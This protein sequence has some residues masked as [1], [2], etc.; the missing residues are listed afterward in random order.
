MTTCNRS[1]LTEA[2]AIEA[3]KSRPHFWRKYQC[4]RCGSWHLASSISY[5]LRRRKA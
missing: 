1:P 3:L 4:N 5:G 2:S